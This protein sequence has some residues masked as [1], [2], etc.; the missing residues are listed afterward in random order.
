MNQKVLNA[1]K[2]NLNCPVD[3]YRQA[4]KEDKNN[5]NMSIKKKDEFDEIFGTLD[6]NYKN[7]KR[8]EEDKVIE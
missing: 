3:I 1:Q 5:L 2:R 6:Y 4:K 7:K 8:E